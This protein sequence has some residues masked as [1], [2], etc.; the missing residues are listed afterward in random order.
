[1]EFKI[2]KTKGSPVRIKNIAT[3]YKWANETISDGNIDWDRLN[4]KAMLEIGCTPKKAEY[5]LGEVRKMAENEQLA[6]NFEKR[7]RMGMHD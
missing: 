2:Q 7:Y 5:Y 6:I 4:K 3:I 1:M